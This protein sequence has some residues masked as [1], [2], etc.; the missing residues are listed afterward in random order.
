M[1]RRI[2]QGPETATI[3]I[4]KVM[5]RITALRGQG[6]ARMCTEPRGVSCQESRCAKESLAGVGSKLMSSVTDG[7]AP[8]KAPIPRL[9]NVRFVKVQ[10]RWSSVIRIDWCKMSR[11]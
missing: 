4:A 7:L 3:N 8:N 11:K 1:E 5:I 6:R 9:D 2:S 10:K